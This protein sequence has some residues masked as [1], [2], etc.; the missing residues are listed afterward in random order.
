[1]IAMTFDYRQQNAVDFKRLDRSLR[2]NL[3]I[4]MKVFGNHA[5]RRLRK[6][7]RS[8]KYEENSPPWKAAKGGGKVLFHTNHISTTL[9][10]DVLPGVG[11]ILVTVKVGWLKQ[12]PHPARKTSKNIQD[13]VEFLQEEH[14]WE[15]SW[16]SAK[17]FW[18]KVPSEWKKANPPMF[19]GVF[20]SPARSFMTD[21][22]NDV[23]LQ[24]SFLHYV[25]QASERAMKGK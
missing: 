7:M 2:R 19:K 16:S 4:S 15:P 3:L 5:V 17:A 25:K 1:M 11:N 23:E 10:S 20:E 8:G 24:T 22:R 6:I 9:E 12:T 18:A 14:T 21:A 13:I